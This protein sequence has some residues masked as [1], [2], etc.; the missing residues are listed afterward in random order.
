MTM[1]S[2]N[3]GAVAVRETLAEYLQENWSGKWP[4]LWQNMPVQPPLPEK[5]WLRFAISIDRIAAIGLGRNRAM[6]R[7]SIRITLAISKGEGMNIMDAAIDQMIALFSGKDIG[8]I[9]LGNVRMGQG[10][11]ENGFYINTMTIGFSMIQ[12]DT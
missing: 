7:G 2:Q 1:E 6:L 8:G 10:Q 9:R 12:N 3:F 4:V 5:G 11:N